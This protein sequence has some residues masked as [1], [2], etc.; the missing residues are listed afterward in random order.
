LSPLFCLAITL[1]DSS[2]CMLIP[3][4]SPVDVVS[5]SCRRQQSPTTYSSAKQL[6]CT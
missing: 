3:H 5:L 4:S 6:W 1:I 2:Q